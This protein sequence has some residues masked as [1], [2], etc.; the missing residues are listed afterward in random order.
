MRYERPAQK[1]CR[2]LDGHAKYGGGVG[3]DVPEEYWQVTCTPECGF[4]V[5]SHSRDELTTVVQSH[6]KRIHQAEMTPPQVQP[7]IKPA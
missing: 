1:P 4:Q 3:R 6:S 2:P 7:M 5:R